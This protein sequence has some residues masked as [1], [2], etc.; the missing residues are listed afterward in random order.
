MRTRFNYFL[1]ILFIIFLFL[2]LCDLTFRD[3]WANLFASVVVVIFIDNIVTHIELEKNKVARKIIELELCSACG[4]LLYGMSP[5]LDRYDSSQF[6]WKWETTL[7]GEY[8][9]KDWADYYNQ[10]RKIRET[11]LEE[12]RQI[13]DKRDYLSP[14]LQ[15]DVFNLISKLKNYRWS[16]WLDIQYPDI[17]DYVW[18]LKNIS[19][20]AEEVSELSFNTI[21]DGKLLKNLLYRPVDTKEKIKYVIKGTEKKELKY[22]LRKYENLLEQSKRFKKG[23]EKKVMQRK[24][25]IIPEQPNL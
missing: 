1:G 20:L 25:K 9:E 12:F 8:A 6:D 15:N 24:N 7:K 17:R 19:E 5:K 4:N 14:E 22:E 11:T 2:Y 21:K 16:N 18:K 3:L 23:V 13:S 10:I